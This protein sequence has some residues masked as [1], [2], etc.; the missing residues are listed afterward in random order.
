MFSSL[1]R[2]SYSSRYTLAMP[3]KN[4][5]LSKTATALVKKSWRVGADKC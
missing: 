4:R 2:F 3:A 1:D 5:E